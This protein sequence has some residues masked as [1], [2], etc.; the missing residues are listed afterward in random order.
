MS[1]YS[2]SPDGRAPLDAGIILA[3][4]GK[5]AVY[6]QYFPSPFTGLAGE[7]GGSIIS[8]CTL[9][10]TTHSV[11]LFMTALRGQNYAPM[12]L[13][14][15]GDDLKQFL[16]WVAEHRVDWETPRR[17]SRADVEG[18]MS[19]LAGRHMTGITRVR[20]LA[21]IRKFWLFGKFCGNVSGEMGKWPP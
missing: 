16:A 18:F 13:R 5:M 3:H 7:G 17:F 6:S 15:Y 14:A 1:A 8:L 9:W 19:H 4:N 11:E 2:Q 20:K 12:T 10:T 21:A